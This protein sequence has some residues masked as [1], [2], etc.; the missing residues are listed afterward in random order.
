MLDQSNIQSNAQYNILLSHQPQ[1]LNKFKDYPID[2][3]L[4]GHTHRG[5]IIPF[6]WLIGLFNDYAYGRYDEEGKTAFVSQGIGGW[7]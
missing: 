5:Q 7:G 1:K 4:N 6:S 3:T 2:L